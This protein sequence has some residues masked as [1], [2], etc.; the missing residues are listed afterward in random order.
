[1][2]F[3]HL[4]DS[5]LGYRQYGLLEREEDFYNVFEKTIDKIIESE[6]DFVVH[7]GD[8]FDNS[9]PSINALLCFQNGLARLKEA[10]I[11]IYAIAGNHDTVLR[12]GALPP[13]KLFEKWGLNVISQNN[14]CYNYG[15]VLICGVPFLPKTQRRNLLERYEALAAKANDGI[16]SIFLSH[17]GIDKFLNFEDDYGET[18]YEV[19]IDE[20]PKNFDYYA[21]GHIHNY[22]NQEFGKGRLVYPGSMEIWK[23]DEYKNYLKH[24]KGFCIVDLNTEI[25]EVERVTVDLPRK[26]L[27]EYIDYN[28]LDSKL[29]FIRKELQ[30][31][32]EKPILDLEIGNA[33]FNPSE[34]YDKIYAALNDLTL[35]I[36]PKYHQ[37]D[38]G[39]KLEGIK[40]GTINPR[41]MLVEA[42]NEKYNNQ[43]INH[44][45]IDLLDSLSKNN[46]ENAKAISDTYY[47]ENYQFGES[48]KTKINDSDN[49]DESDFVSLNDFTNDSDEESSTASLNEDDEFSLNEEYDSNVEFSLN[50]EN[51]SD[52]EFSLNESIE[53]KNLEEYPDSNEKKEN[54]KSKTFTLDDFS[55]GGK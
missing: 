1:M 26:F 20:L 21:M 44:L 34:V 25:P 3:A 7:S 6:V 30:D 51:E 11:P 54:K 17:Q 28:E 5:H 37:K 4:A 53:S 42:L 55:G 2:R 46:I 48:D 9:R 22:I 31:L 23:A 40:A 27:R 33:N 35:M 38:S 12:K 43:E 10:K 15:G 19:S 45:S 47:D 52:Y 8:L 32:D 14:P 29:A 36:R 13:Q 16:K 39:V 18:A 50:E 49:G 41:A 24:G